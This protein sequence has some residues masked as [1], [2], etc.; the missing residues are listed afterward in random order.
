MPIAALLCLALASPAAASSQLD[1]LIRGLEAH[2]NNL[3]T[4]KAS[5]VQLYQEGQGAPTRE[6]AGVVYLRKPG[7]MR[8]EYTRPEVKLFVSDG[9]M[10]YFYAPED[11]QVTRMRAAEST[12]L[13]TPLRFLLGKLNLK[14]SF[15]R[16][17]LA[18][19]VAPLDPG[20]PVLRLLPKSPDERFRELLVEVDQRTRIRRLVIYETD[21]SRTEFRLSGEEPNPSL[22]A[23][24]FQF[25]VPPGVE[26]VDERS[27][28]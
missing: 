8:W 14:R 4:L 21:G 18:G 6:E 12:D 7:R 10:V 22:D 3:Q 13:R 11:R 1:Q 24:L 5:F 9:K 2:Y 26:I 25:T 20:N 23:R 27:E 28:R 15:S 19:D 17:E 16:V